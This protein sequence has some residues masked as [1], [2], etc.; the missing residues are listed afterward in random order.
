[1]DEEDPVLSHQTQAVS[2]LN[3]S[4]E[5]VSVLTG[6]IGKYVKNDSIEVYSSGWVQDR[7]IQNIIYFYFTF[8]KVLIREKPDAVFSHMTDVQSFLIF[9]ILKLLRLKHYLWYAHKTYSPWLRLTLPWLAGVFTSTPGSFP[10]KIEKLYP[11]GQAIQHQDFP[12]RSLNNDYSFNKL[13]HVGRF[14]SAKNIH[15]LIEAAS[16]F[17]I[18]F[19]DLVLT[20]IGSPS[21]KFENLYA[22]KI[23]FNYSDF[24]TNK[25][26]FFFEK[27]TRENVSK[28]LLDN[29]IFIH[30]YKGSLDKTLL[31][32]TLSGLPVVTLNPEY[33]SIFGSWSKSKKVDVNFLVDEITFLTTLSKKDLLSEL[34]TR[35]ELIK[36]HHS[37][38][39]WGSSIARIIKYDEN[40]TQYSR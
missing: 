24:E 40:K 30:G 16:H 34:A 10:L 33:I 5:K 22:E 23:K 9:P 37:L 11:V 18:N 19:P 8:F 25:W 3:K 14:D 28:M 1:M 15:L 29:E 39:N 38:E 13:I 35:R 32:A 21:N 2:E 17:K 20:L 27:I 26:L 31:E 7:K 6:K 12:M 4:F 36:S